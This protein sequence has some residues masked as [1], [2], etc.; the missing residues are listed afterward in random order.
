MHPILLNIGD[1][2][3]HWYGVLIAVGA[4]LAV[5][6]TNRWGD[7]AGLPKNIFGD[8]G[9]WAILL[10]IAGARAWYVIQHPEGIDTIG[11]AINVRSGGLVSYGGLLGVLLA[12]GIV[13]IRKKLP[14]LKVLD[15]LAPVIPLGHVFG[16]LGCFMAGC[17]HGHETDAPWAVIFPGVEASSVQVDLI[18]VPIH[19]TQLYAAAYLALLA[20]FLIWYRNR[21][22]FDGEL[23]LIYLTAYPILRSINEVFRG[24]SVRGYLIEGVVTTAQAMSAVVALVALVGWVWMGKVNKDM[25][26]KREKK[27]A[28]ESA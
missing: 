26:A 13:I 22:R 14:V 27:A 7:Q 11:Q 2:A 10:G 17:C 21:K 19:P 18:G 1:F 23:I 28:A 24:D 5:F 4:I 9:F 12:F 8:L 15:I 6:L 20:G 3:L 25:K 16:R